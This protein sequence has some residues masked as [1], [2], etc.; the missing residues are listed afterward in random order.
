[1]IL[2][3]TYKNIDL[4]GDY[5]PRCVVTSLRSN[6]ISGSRLNLSIKRKENNA[7]NNNR[8][9]SL[10]QKMVLFGLRVQRWFKSDGI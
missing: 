10:W 1:M 5:I 9:V 8:Q 6:R 7:A 3:Y 2:H 4:Q